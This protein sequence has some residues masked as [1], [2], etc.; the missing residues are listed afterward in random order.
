[1]FEII[2]KTFNCNEKE[3]GWNI[4]KQLLAFALIDAI[5]AAQLAASRLRMQWIICVAYWVI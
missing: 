2:F 3:D 4:L 1:M 5:S